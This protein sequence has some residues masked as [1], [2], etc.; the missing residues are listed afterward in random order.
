MKR[1]ISLFVLLIAVFLVGLAAGCGPT[2]APVPTA[3]STPAPTDTPV[4]TPTLTPS[5]TSTATATA[6]PTDTPV[7]IAGITEPVDVNGVLVQILAAEWKE[8]SVATGFKLK[9]G[10]QSLMLTFKLQGEKDASPADLLN[11][12]EFR[13]MMV[14]DENEKESP[15]IFFNLPISSLTGSDFAQLDLFFAVLKDATQWQV[16]FVDGQVIKLVSILAAP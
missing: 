7:P 16:R 4:N 3:T 10:Y 2:P 8:P 13:K 9:A 5:P 15:V 14:V 12:L 1:K 6:I 11:Q